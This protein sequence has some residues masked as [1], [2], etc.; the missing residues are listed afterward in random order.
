MERQYQHTG[1]VM[2]VQPGTLALGRAEGEKILEEFFVNDDAA[3]KCDEHAHGGQ[4]NHPDA[5]IARQVEGEM[6]AKKEP[7]TRCLADV[8]RGAAF[9]IQVHATATPLFTAGD[10]QP[11]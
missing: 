11:W 6:E 2:R 3:D 8:K 5:D 7:A 1:G 4:A 10:G 9:R